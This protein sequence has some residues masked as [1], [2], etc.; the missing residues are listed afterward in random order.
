MESF[1]IQVISSYSSPWT[2]IHTELLQLQLLLFSYSYPIP[3]VN[4]DGNFPTTIHMQS[5]CLLVGISPAMAYLSYP[6]RRSQIFI[7]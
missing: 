7:P 2:K 5:A 4:Q 6:W 3:A 1:L